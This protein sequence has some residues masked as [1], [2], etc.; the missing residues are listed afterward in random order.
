MSRKRS[1]FA[2]TSRNL[3]A[4]LG[5]ELRELGASDVREVASGVQFQGTLETAYSACLWSRVANRVLLPLHAVKAPDADALYAGVKSI[6]WSEHMG[7]DQTLAVDF[8]CAKS[9]I[10]HSQYGALRVKDA[11]VDQFREASGRRPSV[12]RAEPDL[13]I[14]VYLFRDLARIAIDLS[15][16]SM[17]RRNYRLSTSDAPLKENL[18]AAILLQLGWPE[19]AGKNLPFYDPMCGSGTFLIEAAMIAGDVAPGL[20]RQYFGFLG[21]KGHQ[22]DLWQ[23]LVAGAKERSTAGRP[24]IPPIAGSDISDHAIQTASENI[25]R[26]GFDDVISLECC[27]VADASPTSDTPG[28]LVT[29][30]PYGVRLN[31]DERIG[32]LYASLGNSV[33]RNFPGWRLG[34]F[35]GTPGLLFRLR[36]DVSNQLNIDNGGIACKLVGGLIPDGPAKLPASGLPVASSSKNQSESPIE[37]FSVK[38]S[39]SEVLESSESPSPWAKARTRKVANNSNRGADAVSPANPESNMFANRLEKNQRK[40]KGW[41]K[42]QAVSAYRLYD[43]DI[44]EYAVAVDIYEA[45][46]RHVVVQEYRAPSTVDDRRA[47]ERMQLVLDTL[48]GALACEPR[49]I[50][51]KLRQK[52]KGSDQYQRV[53]TIGKEHTVHENGCAYLL[54]FDDYLDVGVFPDHRKVRRYIQDHSKQKRFLNLY[55]YTGVATVFAAVGGAKSSVTVDLSNTYTAWCERN[56]ELNKLDLSTHLVVKA[57]VESWL[58]TET[59]GLAGHFDLVLLDPPTFSNSSSM[60]GNWD[61]QRDHLSM[62]DRVMSLVAPDGLLI[63]SNNYRR[64]RLDPA[65]EQKFM[66]ED[67]SRWSTD[68]D[69]E[70]HGKDRHCWFVRHRE[71]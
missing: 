37:P 23:S 47:S 41:I 69:F 13:R 14:N 8:Y 12:D 6:D 34:V 39:S 9:A 58:E 63:F 45:E 38:P 16:T 21:W 46:S 42:Q 70:R 29:N 55:G 31:Q 50:H 33:T 48:P 40:L 11:I 60:D 28:L 62:I 44:P 3:E 1:F 71:T 57:D 65:I 61:V 66:V 5:A 52:Q 51:R 17:H 54:N 4:L 22:A 68:R 26:A 15:G 10:T 19:M 30:P 24:K 53:S 18:A 64:F 56:L 36:C 35:S 20:A 2:S 67:R 7:V 27:D 49:N 59:K 32:K 25:A 43:A